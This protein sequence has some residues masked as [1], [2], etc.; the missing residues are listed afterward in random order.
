LATSEKARVARGILK[1]YWR[2]GKGKRR[3]PASIT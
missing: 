3:K 2:R 1:A